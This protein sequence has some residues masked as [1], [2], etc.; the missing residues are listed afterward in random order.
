MVLLSR[1]SQEHTIASLC[2]DPDSTTHLLLCDF[3]DLLVRVASANL[4]DINH[5]LLKGVEP[6]HLT[7]D[8]SDDLNPL[9]SA[10]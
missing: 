2:K 1:Q 4:Q 10:L 3:V 8:G 9:G 7:D 6:A 5:A